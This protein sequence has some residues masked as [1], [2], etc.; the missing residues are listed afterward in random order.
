MTPA[1]PAGAFS[2]LVAAEVALTLVLLFGAGL[3]ARSL[4][5]VSRVPL[6][7]M[8][9]QVVAVD[10]SLPGARFTGVNEHRQFYDAVMASLA[11]TPGL[12]GLGV[13]GALP[14]GPTASTTMVPQGGRDDQ[15]SDADVIPV[16]PGFFQALRVPLVR[17]RL[18]AE[19]DL[20][21]TLP[22]AVINDAAARQFWPAGVDPIGRTIEMRDWGAPYT[23]TVVGIVGNVRQEGPD[24]P[25]TTA[26]Y[27][28]IAQFPQTT[29]TETIVART[30]GPVDAIV[31]RIRD[32]VRGADPAQPLARSGAMSDRIAAALAPRRFNLMLLGAFAAAA[33]LLAAV[34][35]YGVVAFAMAART[36]EIGI[37]VAL[38]AAPRHIA[39]LA[40]VGGALPVAV[41]IVA[42]LATSS[43]RHDSFRRSCTACRRETRRHW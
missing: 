33:L 40:F 6:A 26:V 11:G 38:G 8:Q 35:I 12:Q 1:H 24:Q 2:L 23:A 43:S 39:W 25:V 19:H 5:V 37:R 29:L 31:A 9:H 20:A 21:Q 13:T 3:L 17:G 14:L 27:V 18:I 7:S 22:V 41:G 30:S 32:A 10:L 42:G 16:T 28:P 4:L 34:G 15:Q 36:R